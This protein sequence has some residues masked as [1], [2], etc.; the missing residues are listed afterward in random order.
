[1]LLAAPVTTLGGEAGPT[2]LAV[3]LA[4][5]AAVARSADE[6][7]TTNGFVDVTSYSSTSSR[8]PT[9]KRQS[10][11]RPRIL[12]RRIEGETNL[13]DQRCLFAERQGARIFERQRTTVLV[14]GRVRVRV[15]LRERSREP[16][17]V[18][19]LVIGLALRAD[20]GTH[21]VARAE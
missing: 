13:G 21:G 19:D 8:S 15:E 12:P 18:K 5:K 7:L 16:A 4:S 10:W 20:R 2:A 17:V 6:I 1:M 3:P 14:V 11:F 9:R